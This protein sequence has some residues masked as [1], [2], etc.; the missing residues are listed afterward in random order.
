[1]R[2]TFALFVM[3][4]AA[5]IAPA[6]AAEI[7]IA[8]LDQN[9]E[10]VGDAVVSLWPGEKGRLPPDP[11]SKAHKIDQSNEAFVPFVTVMRRGDTVVFKNS[12]RTRHHVYSFSPVK[13]FELV[14]NPNETSQSLKFDQSGIAAIGCN[15]HDKML[16]YAF[17]TDTPW[18]ALTDAQGHGQITNLPKGRFRA[19][20][21]HPRMDPDRPAPE[22]S[23]TVD[24]KANAT[25]NLN[26]IAPA[27]TSG[28]R[29]HY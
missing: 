29:R 17:V 9:G 20:I 24:G 4:F 26:L 27:S 14:L 18:T 3:L 28:H 13:P 22:Q 5:V 11:A 2:H 21:W 10:P 19:E 6:D 15:I 16:A 7:D 8:V 1:M 12:D 25:F 23:L